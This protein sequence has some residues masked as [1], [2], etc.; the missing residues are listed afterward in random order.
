MT[1][2]GQT[3]WTAMGNGCSA[4]H[5]GSNTVAPLQFERR[6][7]VVVSVP[8]WVSPDEPVDEIRRIICLHHLPPLICP[9]SPQDR[10]KNRVSP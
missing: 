4:Q 3:N 8:I 6:F 2:S 7:Q 10:F 5:G 9:C 1:V